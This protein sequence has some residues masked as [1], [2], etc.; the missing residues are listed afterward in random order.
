[1]SGPSSSPGFGRPPRAAQRIADGN[2]DLA[3]GLSDLEDGLV[4]ARTGMAQ[5]RDGQATLHNKLGQLADGSRAG[6]RRAAQQ[7]S[8]SVQRPPHTAGP[9]GRLPAAHRR[10]RRATRRCGGFYLPAKALDDPRL[11][12]A[13]SYYL[14]PDGRT[15]RFVVLG[16]EDS[17]SNP[18]RERSRAVDAAAR[19]ALV[20]TPLA[21]A[22]VGT[23]GIAASN[24]DIHLMSDKDFLLIGGVALLAV[25]LILIWLL[26]SLVAPVMLIGS[27]VLSFIAAM[28][29]SVLFWQVLLG[30]DID[31]TVTST[32][33]IILVAVGSDYNLLMMKRMKDEA[34]NA[35]RAGIARA[36][37]RT[38][39]V[40]TTAGLIFAA[41][42]FAMLF[43]PLIG[44][45]EVGFTIGMGLLLDTFVVRSIVVPSAATLLG[46]R[47]WWPGA[48]PGGAEATCP[49]S[50]WVFRRTIRSPMCVTR[51]S[52]SA[53]HLAMGT[54]TEHLAACRLRARPEHRGPLGLRRHQQR[55]QP[56][57]NRHGDRHET[58]SPTPSTTPSTTPSATSPATPAPTGPAF[59]DYRIGG[60]QRCRGH[61]CGPGLPSAPRRPEGL[62][63]LT[64]TV[65]S[66]ISPTRARA[67]HW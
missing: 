47:L 56:S 5:L 42:M 2:G 62:P 31:W 29:L 25:F 36:V 37:S 61:Q 41:S 24:E 38:G 44:I 18:A 9:G 63:G 23:T 26:R 67:G 66:P 40:I 4:T 53:R 45:K 65:R 27:V 14:S 20:G 28:G 57:G 8:G 50:P 6:R 15:A 64:S 22:K 12:L 11:A 48:A 35:E 46:R 10:R 52:H 60:R 16:Q 55:R 58:V 7:I 43:S 19:R 34:P 1:M 49:H 51:A 39:H 32:A 33:F 17:F 54:S 3:D 59:L 21:D 30:H 13:G